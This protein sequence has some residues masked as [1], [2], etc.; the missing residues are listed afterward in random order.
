MGNSA[1]STSRMVFR[2]DAQL[3]FRGASFAEVSDIIKCWFE[4]GAPLSFTLESFSEVLRVEDDEA[5][6]LF[7]TFDT[8]RNRKVDALEVLAAATIVSDGPMDEK[9]D[10]FFP[11]F[12]FS[13]TGQANFDEANILLHSVT[14]GLSKLCG[15][16]PFEEGEVLSVCHQMFDSHNLPYTKQISKEQLRRW[17]RTDV[18]AAAFVDSFANGYHLSN[19]ECALAAQEQEL[20]KA[21][22]ELAPSRDVVIVDRLR[23]STLFRKALGDPTDK[24]LQAL[25]RSM[26]GESQTIDIQR[27]AEGARAWTIFNAVDVDRRG[28]VEGKELAILLFFHHRE[29]PAESTVEIFRGGLSLG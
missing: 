2:S 23:D 28:A 11:V 9:L 21:F 8:D 22:A 12:D 6:S 18:E 29:E 26:A 19:M 16:Q 20:A 17:L 27:F 5:A 7:S 24:D 10:V 1:L 14:R 3:H 25:L 4:D 13:G 15:T